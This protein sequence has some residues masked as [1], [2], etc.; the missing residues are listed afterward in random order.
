M[1][2]MTGRSL[3]S[4]MPRLN[5][6][7][8]LEPTAEPR[9]YVVRD[10]LNAILEARALPAGIDLKRVFV[11]AMVERIDAGWRLGEFSSRGGS[12]FCTRGSDRCQVGIE[13]ADPG[14]PIGYG[15]SHLTESPGRG[16]WET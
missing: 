4:V 7:D 12:F 1:D 8:P 9:W 15:A 13:A 6:F 3:R 2:R 14:R 11:A 10:R 5:V 16:D